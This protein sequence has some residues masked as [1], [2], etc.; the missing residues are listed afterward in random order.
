MSTATITRPA[1]LREIVLDSLN[2]AYWSRR[3]NVE[4]CRDCSRN[5]A[6]VALCHEEDARLAAEYE[7]AR[8]QI[9]NSPGDPEVLAVTGG[10]ALSDEASNEGELQT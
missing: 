1:T 8:K 10:A 3:A 7:E 5:P 4:E 2:D 9:Q 6:G